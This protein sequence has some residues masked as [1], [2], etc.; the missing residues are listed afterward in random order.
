MK[1]LMKTMIF[2][3]LALVMASCHF[4][5]DYFD[6]NPGGGGGTDYDINMDIQGNWGWL[7]SSG[8]IG[9]WTYYQKDYPHWMVMNFERSKFFIT[10]DGQIVQ[11]GT[12]KIEYKFSEL[13]NEKCYVMT[14]FTDY[15]DPEFTTYFTFHDEIPVKV[16]IEKDKLYIVYP[17]C[18]MFDS[19]FERNA[20]I[21]E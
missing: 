10:K 1:T 11:S 15:I 5:D 17:C 6:D 16:K 2:A 21:F 13:F 14:T 9:G 20:I 3:A 7:Q 19:I 8:G 4:P 18:D 12:Y